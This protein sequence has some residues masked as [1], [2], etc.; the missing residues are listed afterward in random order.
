M[1]INL[2]FKIAAI[3]I[4]VA[5][6][7]QV[8]VRAGREDQAMMTTLAGLVIVLTMVI[9]EISGLF[10]TV[11]TI[12]N[13]W[14][15]RDRTRGTVFKCLIN[16]V[17]KCRKKYKVIL[18]FFDKNRHENETFKHCPSCL[19]SQE[20]IKMEVIKIIGIALIALII[21]I[22]LKQYRPEF[23]IYISLLTGV[24]ILLL[25]MDKLTGIINLLQSLASKTS[26]NSTFLALLIKITGIAFL[27]E[28]A[29]SI[30]KDSG[31]AAIASKIEIGTKII[32]ISM[33]IPIISSLLEI[34]LRIL[35]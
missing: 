4:L 33:S 22:L 9:K 27:S 5:V 35:P 8:L 16:F 17:E 7:H 32:I 1:D 24:L 25:V 31:E 6:L 29:V 18:C 13:L 15:K 20:R 30:C 26:I 34:I 14:D 2:L 3:G 12:F 19:I 10:D 11:R 23:A 28:F 21:I